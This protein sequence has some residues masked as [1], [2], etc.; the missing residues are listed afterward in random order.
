MEMKQFTGMALETFWG[1]VVWSVKGTRLT[2]DGA[3][4]LPTAG[5]DAGTVPDHPVLGPLVGLSHSVRLLVDLIV[6]PFF[7]CQ[8][9]K[10]M[11]CYDCFSVFLRNSKR[12]LHDR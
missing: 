11:Y 10:R 2:G 9:N 8:K 12:E 7:C 3:A 6:A 5:A 1:C 4:D